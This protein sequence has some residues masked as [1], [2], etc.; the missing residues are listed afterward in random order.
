[1]TTR[2]DW[3]DPYLAR[4]G[5]ADPGTPSLAALTALHQ[6]HVERIAYENIDIQL[7]RPQGIDPAESIRRVLAGRGGYCFNLNGA[8]SALLIALGYKVTRHRG[9]VHGE[10]STPQPDEYGNHM[11]VTV[12]L[13]GEIWM[14]DAGLG[15]AHYEPMRL[16]EGEHR[17]G[18][19]AFRL[20]RIESTP[21]DPGD[22]IASG[23]V[24]ADAAMPDNTAASDGVTASTGTGTSAPTTS[25]PAERWRFVHDTALGTG[26][27]FAMDFALTPAQWTDFSAHHAELSTAPTSPFV[28]SAQVFRR[29]KRGTDYIVGCTLH[30]VEG[31]DRHAERELATADEWFDAAT[32]LFG[33]NLTRISADDR[34][35][36]WKRM[37]LAH[38]QWLATRAA[39]TS[40]TAPA[41]SA[42]SLRDHIF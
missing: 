18:P 29:D 39:P 14:V 2:P 42:T 15:N 37:R 30:R 21:T 23:A 4:L 34:K 33:L 11:A 36:M 17:Q 19:F 40:Q 24:I 10:A 13:D 31:L 20:E 26:S 8:F 1:M 3:L 7:G 32:D 35:R 12:D 5:V 41:G 22:A 25:A 16:V 6:A 27:F 9:G 38:T 28:K